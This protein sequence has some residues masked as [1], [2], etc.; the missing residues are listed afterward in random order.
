LAN[1]QARMEVA[2]AGHARTLKEH[3]FKQRFREVFK[4]MGL[5]SE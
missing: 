4:R 1:D 2:N 5:Q 3:T